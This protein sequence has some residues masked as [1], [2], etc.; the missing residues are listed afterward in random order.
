MLLLSTR[1]SNLSPGMQS[2]R[3]FLSIALLPAVKVP[4]GHGLQLCWPGCGLNVCAGHVLQVM[5]PL[6]LC[7]CCWP[8]GHPAVDYK[9]MEAVGIVNSSWLQR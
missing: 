3:E 1:W 5:L 2:S 9:G 8:G 6:A 4:L 7:C